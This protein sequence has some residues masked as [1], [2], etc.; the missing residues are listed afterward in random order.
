MHK[1]LAGE[2]LNYLFVYKLQLKKFRSNT[3]DTEGLSFLYVF[4]VQDKND[5]IGKTWT[6]NENKRSVLRI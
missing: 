4:R 2:V 1:D 3:Q 5:G 6:T